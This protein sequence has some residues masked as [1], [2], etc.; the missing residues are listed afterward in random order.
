MVLIFLKAMIFPLNKDVKNFLL[1]TSHFGEE[2]QGKLDLYV[3]NNKLNEANFR[4]RPDPIS[5]N[6]VRNKNP[7]EILF[8]D[9]K[10]FDAKNP[11]IVF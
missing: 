2:I 3:T 7:T 5:K 11:V 10:Y 9:V 4:R 8:K 6:I 1:A